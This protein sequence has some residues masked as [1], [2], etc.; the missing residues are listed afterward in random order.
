MALNGLFEPGTT[1]LEECKKR[2]SL[3]EDD[4]RNNYLFVQVCN[5]F[6]KY[7]RCEKYVRGDV[8]MV[9]W[10]EMTGRAW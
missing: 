10:I 5:P 6:L 4:I 9:F 7:L 8:L 2:F 3:Y 1:S